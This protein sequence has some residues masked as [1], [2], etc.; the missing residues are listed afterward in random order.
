MSNRNKDTENTVQICKPWIRWQM[1][2]KV[3]WMICG[4]LVW[5]LESDLYFLFCPL[6][7]RKELKKWSKIQKESVLKWN[8]LEN[9]LFKDIN[10]SWLNPRK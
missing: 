7:Q 10:S 1:G 3:R 4:A 5:C 8:A 9:D 2:N 6:Y